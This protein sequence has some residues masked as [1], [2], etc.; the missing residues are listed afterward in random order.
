MPAKQKK[1]DG[2]EKLAGTMLIDGSGVSRLDIWE[3]VGVEAVK[4]ITGLQAAHGT[5]RGRSFVETA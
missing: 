3:K 5:A 4:Y 2:K 1:K